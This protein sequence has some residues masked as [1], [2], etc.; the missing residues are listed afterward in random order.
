MTKISRRKAREEAVILLYQS[1]LLEKD[2]EKTIAN[3]ISLGRE[4][5]VF[6]SEIV[7]G[8]KSNLDEIDTIIKRIVENWTIDRIAFIDR[9][10][11]RVGI[12]EMLFKNEIP[13]KV[14]VDEAIEI[15]K[16]F[17]QKEDTPKF[18]NGVLGKIF[19]EIQQGKTLKNI[20]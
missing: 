20:G 13:L 8:V 7:R 9:N 12:Y 18:V 4:I 19:L 17:G 5:D 15:A 3:E 11:I 10:I 2:I 14:S 16:R 6:T 1:D